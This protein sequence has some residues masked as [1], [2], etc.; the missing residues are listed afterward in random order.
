MYKC[1]AVD[2]WQQRRGP[3]CASGLQQAALRQSGCA[4]SM[5]ASFPG[6]ITVR[7]ETPCP[8]RCL[9]FDYVGKDLT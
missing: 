4:A 3:Q 2:P 8:A 7:F 1:T 6:N 5:H 9:S